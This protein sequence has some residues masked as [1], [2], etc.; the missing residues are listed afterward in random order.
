MSI[1]VT[2]R[3]VIRRWQTMKS[4][5]EPPN[6]DFIRV[7]S[8]SFGSDASLQQTP[9]VSCAA[10]SERL[11]NQQQS[12]PSSQQ[13][14]G[15]VMNMN[16][17]RA[18]PNSS[19]TISPVPVTGTNFPQSQPQQQGMDMIPQYMNPNLFSNLNFPQNLGGLNFQNFTPN[20]AMQMM[21]LSNSSQMQGKTSSMLM[22]LLDQVG[23]RAKRK[24]RKGTSDEASPAG[25]SSW[26]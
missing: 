3:A 16:K 8:S 26:Q 21:A 17:G 9:D 19:F 6:Q 10:E 22:G 23:Q 20:M 13:V 15:M 18:T 1:P 25:T 4:K 5:Y 12:Q 11:Q 2:V 7:N 24:K 14:P